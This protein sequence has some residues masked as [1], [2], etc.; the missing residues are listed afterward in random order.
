MLPLL[1]RLAR[2]VGPLLVGTAVGCSISPKPEPPDATFDPTRVNLAP[3]EVRGGTITV[4]GPA[5]TAS[6]PGAVVRI[7]NLDSDAA[8]VDALVAA[9]GSFQA[10]V[11]GNPGD[12]LRVQLLSDAERLPPVDVTESGVTVPPAGSPD[13]GVVLATSPYG[14]CLVTDP[15]FELAL[16]DR[17]TV[18]VQNGCATS[19]DI[20]E[21]VLRRATAGVTIDAGVTWPVTLAAGQSLSISIVVGSGSSFT[22]EILIIPILGPEVDRRAI[23]LYAP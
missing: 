23:T 5:G 4:R 17:G 8:P 1:V 12:E 7:Y 6:P 9:D 3:E 11:Q 10:V 15:A 19:L 18:V 22:E 16:Q 21:P 14:D 20:G 2:L 13:T